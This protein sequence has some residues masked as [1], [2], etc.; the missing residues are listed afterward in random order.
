MLCPSP[1]GD[2]VEGIDDSEVP[3]PQL[4]LDPN[5][6]VGTKQYMEWINVF[7][8]AYDKVTFAPV[9]ATP[10]A[11]PTP[12]VN[13]GI[14][15]CSAVGGDG[16][17]IFD[18]LASRW[19][20]AFHTSPPSALYNYC[21][22]VSSTD[23]LTSPAL[24]WYTYVF[25]LN[26][27]LG[28]NPQGQTYFPDWPKFGTWADAYYASFDMEDVAQKHLNIGSMACA[29]DR[30]NMLLGNPGANP[31]Q[32]FYANPNQNGTLFLGH[33]L[34]PADVE[35]TTAPPAGRD[36]FFVSIQNPP[37]DGQ[38]PHVQYHQLVGLSCRF[39]HSGPTRLSRIFRSR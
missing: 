14:T 34:I 7:Y 6:A 10:L 11:G 3:T 2:L 13:N 9:W 22:A 21:I 33:S 37:N 38:D 31:M 8:Q 28:T 5:G 4:D 36:E 17:V 24:V 20:I 32:C 15:N 29:F 1:N 12:W 18:R 35:G 25:P 30:T 23:D 39:G 16:V 26:A 19:V 27:A